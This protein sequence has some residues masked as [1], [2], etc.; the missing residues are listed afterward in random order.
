M[1]KLA[2]IIIRTVFAFVAILFVPFFVLPMM[3]GII[4]IGSIS[5]LALC[6]WIFC[7]SAAPI[8][9]AIRKLF[10]RKKLTKI[11]Y[12]TVNVC[13]ILFAVYGGIVTS[14]MTWA[15]LQTPSQNAT[16]VVLGAQVKPW[17]PSAV[18]SG[19]ISGAENYLEQNKDADAVLSGGQGVD[20]P[21]SEAECIYEELVKGGIAE[22]RLYI[23]DKSTNTTENIKYSQQ[24][25]EKNHLNPNLAVAT[26][27]YHQL[28]VRI[29]ANQ[30]GIKQNVGAVNSDTSIL[31]LPVFTVREWFALPYQV[32]FR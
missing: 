13:F 20:E 31:Y 12:R 10:C 27:F 30:L 2:L 3:Q 22:N 4:N 1:K 29:I 11:I 15:A 32:L 7:V 14:L 23:E 24:I 18:L 8:H 21:T 25:I 19:R 26:D 9:R 5:G 28:R 17:G 16:T 6:V